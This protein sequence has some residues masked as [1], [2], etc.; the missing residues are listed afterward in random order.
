MN[1]A[2]LQFSGFEE[3]RSKL[4]AAGADVVKIATEA[5]EATNKVIYDAAKAAV[6][7]QNLPAQGRFSTGRTEA[8]L[9]EQPIIEVKGNNV[10]AHVGF[11]LKNGGFPSIFLMHGTPRMKPARGLY[12]AFYGQDGEIM[13][14]QREVFEKAMERIFGSEG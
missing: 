9:R 14:V 8:A 13:Q 4:N 5:L 2:K 12:E 7:K 6:Q 3:M 10:I 1:K 11:D